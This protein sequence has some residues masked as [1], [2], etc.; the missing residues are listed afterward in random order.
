MIE[1]ELKALIKEMFELEDTSNNEINFKSL[2]LDS[3]DTMELIL[4]IEEKY[5]INIPDHELTTITNFKDLLWWVEH[6]IQ[7]NKGKY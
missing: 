4:A 5:N 2:G 6:Y 7:K 1:T 3:L